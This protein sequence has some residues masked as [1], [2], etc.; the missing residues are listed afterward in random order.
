MGEGVVDAIFA[1]FDRFGDQHYGEDATQR[2]HALQTAELARRAGCT[3]AMIAAALLH[4][5]GQFLDDA[6]SAAET[7]GADAQHETK[8]AAYLARHFPDSVTEPVRLHVVAKR[9]LCAVD[10][11][12][13]DALS[14]ASV[15]SL[16]L[17]GGAMT[18]AEA[19]CFEA[20]PF[21]ADAVHIRRFDDMGKQ[22][23]WSVPTLETHRMR[24]LAL[25]RR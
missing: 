13:R 3:E 21:F 22:P 2:A 10:P 16:S 18:H 14:R 19:R 25:L 4:D 23:A 1:L 5:I 20:T 24:L 15:L 17:Q 9:Y 7:H 8:G 6:G 11:T 12:Y